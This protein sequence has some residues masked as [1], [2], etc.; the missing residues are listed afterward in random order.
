MSVL[1]ILD[2]ELSPAP[3]AL[4]ANI[5]NCNSHKYSD[6]A[7]NDK[8]AKYI[9]ENRDRDRRADIDG[10]CKNCDIQPVHVVPGHH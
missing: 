10:N 4:N 7:A 3:R 9:F 6:D 8:T 1:S 5:H 2:R